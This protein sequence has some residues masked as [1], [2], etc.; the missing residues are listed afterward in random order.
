MQF[1]TTFMVSTA[2]KKNPVLLS[3]AEQFFKMQV[4]IVLLKLAN[5]LPFELAMQFSNRPPVHSISKP[6]LLFID[7]VQFLQM[8]GLAG[9]ALRSSNPCE[10]KFWLLQLLSMV[11]EG[12]MLVELIKKPI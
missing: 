9:D 10:R 2:V 4:F 3:V 6:A 1:S 12:L 11:E 7:A 5:P 8:I